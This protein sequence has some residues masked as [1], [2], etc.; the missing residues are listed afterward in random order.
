MI[1]AEKIRRI[2]RSAI[3]EKIDEDLVAEAIFDSIGNMDFSDQIQR[4]LDDAI[5]YKLEEVVGD[6]IDD[7]VNEAVSDVIESIFD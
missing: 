4:V 5:A 1:N 7:V 2:L 6:M 3:E